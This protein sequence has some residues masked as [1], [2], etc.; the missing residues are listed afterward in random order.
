[1]YQ[2]TPSRSG[3]AILETCG[4][5]TTFDTVL[6]IRQSAC[7]TGAERGC[8]DDTTNCVTGEPSN[9]HGSRVSVQVTAGQTYF[10]VVDGYGGARGDY[11]LRVTPP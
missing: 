6:S 10:I 5:A 3:G 1:M 4:T 7:A 2:W 11:T 9:H 8:V